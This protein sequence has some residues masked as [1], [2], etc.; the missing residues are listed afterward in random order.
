[1]L[2]P[3]ALN[4]NVLALARRQ[5]LFERSTRGVI[6]QGGPAARFGPGIPGAVCFYRA[7]TGRKCAFGQLIPDGAYSLTLEGKRAAWVIEHEL[8][9]GL[10]EVDDA[11][12][13]SGLQNAHD[14][15][16][17]RCHGLDLMFWVHWA[18]ALRD[19][20]SAFALDPSVLQE[21]PGSKPDAAT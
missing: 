18:S 8:P 1:M 3:V 5:E 20:V 17:G 2:T 19:V 9:P 15:A 21:I 7:P 12:F 16:A 11:A 6:A 10:F 13:L 4:P 14:V